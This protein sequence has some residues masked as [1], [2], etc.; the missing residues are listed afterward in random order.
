VRDVYLEQLYTFGA[1]S[2]TPRV[3]TVAYYAPELSVIARA[4][5]DAR[6]TPGSGEVDPELPSTTGRSSRRRWPLK[7]R[8]QPIG[9][10]L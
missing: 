3:V 9:F 1:R 4:V 8:Y 6:R 2:G 7:V 10:E 5:T